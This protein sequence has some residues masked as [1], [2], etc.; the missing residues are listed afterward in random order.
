M[1]SSDY[2]DGERIVLTLPLTDL[3]PSA[4]VDALHLAAGTKRVFRT[5]LLADA[6]ADSALGWSR[7]AG[8]AGF[9][10]A[11]RYFFAGLTHQDVECAATLD[12]AV[13]PHEIGFGAL[14]GYPECCCRAVAA[15]GEE[16]IDAHAA[17][18]GRWAFAGRHRLI[19]PGKYRGGLALVSHLPCSPA[20]DQSLELAE[21]VLRYLVSRQ[22]LMQSEPCRR[23]QD[24]VAR[25]TTV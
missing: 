12:A 14:L 3:P 13:T 11:Q 8:L 15:V 19:D 7:A 2:L 17:A 16:N 24:W 9:A 10:D 20:C 23:L 4:F 1:D 25:R 22:A 18:V 5:R 6:P 21:R